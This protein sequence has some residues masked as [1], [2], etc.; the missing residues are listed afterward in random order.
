MFW[1]DASA[2]NIGIGTASPTSKLHVNGSFSV[3]YT[4]TATGIT[5]NATHHTI[6]VTATGQT[7]TLPT[8]VGITGRCYT[9]KLTASG[10]GTV[11]TTSSQTID[12]ST[13]YSL[14]AQYK[15]VTVQSTGS[16]WII[17]ANN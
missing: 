5:A 8:A 6:D 13:T 12:G 17:T 4:A 1:V 9:I 10:T 14:S 16:N 2:D 3:P 15:Y 11:G 7:I